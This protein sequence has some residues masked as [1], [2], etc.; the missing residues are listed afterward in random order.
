MLDRTPGPHVAANDAAE[1]LALQL[2]RTM[3]RTVGEW[4]LIRE[5]DRIL[6]AISG[7]KDSY[8]LL[9]LLWRAR[10]RAPVN[11]ELIAYHLDQGQPGYDGSALRRWLEAFGAPFEIARE[12]T[13]TP[14]IEDARQGSRTTYCR[15]CSRLRRGVLYT[16][17]RRLGCNKVAL[18]HHRDDSLETPKA[19]SKSSAR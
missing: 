5:G 17:A 4:D 16:A 15:L 8:T 2:S 11:F 10:R 3:L 9:D 18:G 14:V 19:S 1:R 12:D 7:G 13:Y 6:V